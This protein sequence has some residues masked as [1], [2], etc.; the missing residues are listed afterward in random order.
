VPSEAQFPGKEAL[1]LLAVPF[2]LDSD[3]GAG[4]A[5]PESA[6][7]PPS[8]VTVDPTAGGELT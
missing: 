5:S 6:R 8:I 4:T 7:G 3:G 1:P 2:A